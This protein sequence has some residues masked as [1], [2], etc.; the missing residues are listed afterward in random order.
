MFAIASRL[1]FYFEYASPATGPV[2]GA[3]E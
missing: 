1:Y 3:A 2:R